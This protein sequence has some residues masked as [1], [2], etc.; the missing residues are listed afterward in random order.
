[1]TSCNTQ[2]PSGLTSRRDNTW[3]NSHFDG[4]SSARTKQLCYLNAHCSTITESW[5]KKVQTSWRPTVKM[6]SST[7]TC[8]LTFLLKVQKS[9]FSA[10]LC[11]KELLFYSLEI[12]Y[13]CCVFKR[14]WIMDSLSFGLLSDFFGAAVCFII[15]KSFYCINNYKQKEMTRQVYCNFLLRI[16]IWN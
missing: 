14:W 15:I 7:W 2:K 16:A 9:F 10:T 1:M 12:K 3:V 6:L 5:K 13:F 4:C 11:S 8:N